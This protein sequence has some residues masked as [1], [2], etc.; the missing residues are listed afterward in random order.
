MEYVDNGN[1]WDRMAREL[2]S[3]TELCNY[4]W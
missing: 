1:V 2:I 4:V 3:Q